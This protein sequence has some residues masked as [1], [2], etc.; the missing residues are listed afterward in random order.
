LKL[1]PT[2]SQE[3]FAQRKSAEAIQYC[4]KPT[5]WTKTILSPAPSGSSL[6]TSRPVSLMVLQDA[7]LCER[8][9]ILVT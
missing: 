5:N 8:E 1:A 6:T 7:G 3:L 2:E 9:A 4:V